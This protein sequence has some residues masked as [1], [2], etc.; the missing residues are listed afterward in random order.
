MPK[1]DAFE[2]AVLGGV[3]L[4]FVA[5]ILF[6]AAADRGRETDASEADD[7]PPAAAEPSI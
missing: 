2:A 1:H 6:V 7:V 3:A 5:A 4:L